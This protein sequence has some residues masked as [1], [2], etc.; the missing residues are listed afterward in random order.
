MSTAGQLLFDHGCDAFKRSFPHI[1]AAVQSNFTAATGDGKWE[2][3]RDCE[4]LF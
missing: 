4:R 3:P 1:A 2:E